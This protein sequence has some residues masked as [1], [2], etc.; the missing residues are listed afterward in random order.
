MSF[1]PRWVTRHRHLA[2]TALQPWTPVFI[3]GDLHIEH[4]LVDGDEV[5]G[6]IDRSEARR[7]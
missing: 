6:I 4:V 7:G 5:T 3:H 1:R 2:E